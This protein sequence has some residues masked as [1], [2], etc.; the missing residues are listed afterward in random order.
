MGITEIV[1]MV[2]QNGFMTVFA[3]TIL[4]FI[5]RLGNTYIEKLSCKGECIILPDELIVKLVRAE[6][7]LH[8]RTKLKMIESVLIENNIDTRK[9]QITRRIE[10]TLYERTRIYLDYFNTLQCK[11]NK[12]GDYYDEVFEMDAFLKEVLAVV[13]RPYKSECHEHEINIKL[14][15]ISEIMIVYQSKANNKIEEELA[16]LSINY[17]HHE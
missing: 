10:N 4:Y 13:F 3:C 12:L 9:D 2:I 11:I 16:R 6:V 7:W 5:I 15:D 17:K 8:S 1:N 14:K